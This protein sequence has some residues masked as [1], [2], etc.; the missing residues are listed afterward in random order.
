MIIM[1]KKDIKWFVKR[2]KYIKILIKTGQPKITYY[3]G[4]RKEEIVL[5]EELKKLYEMTEDIYLHIKEGWLQKMIADL[6]NGKSDLFLFQTYPCGRSTYYKIKKEFREKIYRC[7]IAN[8][9]VAYQE[10][11]ERGLAE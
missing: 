2:Y 1:T 10:L 4:K 11:L 8:D 7:C 3:V 5:T 6:L 9:L